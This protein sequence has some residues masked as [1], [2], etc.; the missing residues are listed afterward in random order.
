MNKKDRKDILMNLVGLVSTIATIILFYVTFKGEENI[1]LTGALIVL[2]L[3]I[4]LFANKLGEILR[5]WDALQRFSKFVP[6][7]EPFIEQWIKDAEQLTPTQKAEMETFNSLYGVEYDPRMWFVI[8]KVEDLASKYLPPSNIDIHLL[9][10]IA[11]RVYNRI[12][13]EL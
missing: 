10:N 12:K 6:F 4:I 3:L 2:Y 7:V 1:Y 8:Q 5:G 13:H 9:Y 11:Q